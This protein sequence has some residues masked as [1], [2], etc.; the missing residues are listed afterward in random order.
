MDAEPTGFEPVDTENKPNTT[1]SA[2]SFHC[3]VA[4]RHS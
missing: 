3:L 2:L 4:N 1:Q